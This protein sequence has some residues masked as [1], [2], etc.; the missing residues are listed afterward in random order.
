MKVPH[1]LW[2]QT[3]VRIGNEEEYGKSYLIESKSEEL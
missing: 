1:A 2:P 3:P